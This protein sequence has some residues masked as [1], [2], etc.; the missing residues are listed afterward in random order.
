MMTRR[1]GDKRGG[2]QLCK[3]VKD[4]Y[5]YIAHNVFRCHIEAFLCHFFTDFY[6]FYDGPVDMQI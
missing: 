4:M 6:L 5:Q 2:L 1:G 3:I